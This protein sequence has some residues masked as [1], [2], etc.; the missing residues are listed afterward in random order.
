M[1]RLKIFVNEIFVPIIVATLMGLMFKS[2]YCIDGDINY[3]LAWI[4][5]G[6]PFG[7]RKMWTWIAPIGHDLGATLGILFFN[8][9]IGGLIGVVVFVWQLFFGTIK[10]LRG[11]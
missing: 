5:I 1:A 6:F 9:I 8:I 4:I 7:F 11:N 2:V 10:F 3:L